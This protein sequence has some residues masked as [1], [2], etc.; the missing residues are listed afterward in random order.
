MEVDRGHGDHANQLKA[1]GGNVDEPV[2]GHRRRVLS[3][4]GAPCPCNEIAKP[5]VLE[6]PD[7][8]G[9][10]RPTEAAMILARRCPS[11]RL[12]RVSATVDRSGSTTCPTT[13]RTTTTARAVSRRVPAG[14]AEPA[15]DGVWHRA[16]KHPRRENEPEALE[17][18]Q[19]DECAKQ[20]RERPAH[21]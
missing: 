7:P 1:R 2:Q 6:M 4:R 15:T 17:H 19:H 11:S 20:R 16:D 10:W 21:R 5:R 3:K 12:P 8:V 14:G 13:K 9:G 18:A